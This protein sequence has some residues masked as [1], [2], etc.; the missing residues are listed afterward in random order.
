MQY[1]KVKFI[2]VAV[3]S[4]NSYKDGDLLYA[5][6]W[7]NYAFLAGMITIAASV[8][9]YIAIFFATAGPSVRGGHTY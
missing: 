7:S 2:F 9:I 3:M 1:F 6:K 4:R 5:T 8:V